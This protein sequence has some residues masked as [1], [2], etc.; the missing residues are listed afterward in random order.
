MEEQKKTRNQQ[1]HNQQCKQK[2]YHKAYREGSPPAASNQLKN[3]LLK[4]SRRELILVPALSNTLCGC[5]R[6]H[7]FLYVLEQKILK[8]LSTIFIIQSWDAGFIRERC[9][10]YIYLFFVLFL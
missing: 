10:E 7:K 8:S 4:T 9:N 1:K 3:I 2:K 6:Y 5:H